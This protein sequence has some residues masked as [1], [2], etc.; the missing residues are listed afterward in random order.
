MHI[1]YCSRDRT[2]NPTGVETEMTEINET[3]SL[4][5]CAENLKTAISAWNKAVETQKIPKALQRKTE[6]AVEKALTNISDVV[7]HVT[8]ARPAGRP[9]GG[10]TK[11]EIRQ[12]LT[13]ATDDQLKRIAAIL[14]G[15]N[16]DTE[17]ENEK[18]E[19]SP[20]SP[21]MV[22]NQESE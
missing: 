4:M 12:G 19:I 2:T 1:L 13:N 18:T 6:T 14:E 10:I 21:D 15:E 22:T 3:P 17:E 8:T 20:F 16:S 7:Y 9:A 5:E 11:T